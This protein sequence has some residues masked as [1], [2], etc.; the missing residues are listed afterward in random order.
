[1]DDLLSLSRVDIGERALEIERFHAEDLFDD[2]TRMMQPLVKAR[3]LMLRIDS[4]EAGIEIE[5]DMRTLRQALLNLVSNAIKFSKAG[6]MISIGCLCTEDKGLMIFVRDEGYGMAPEELPR[7]FEPFRTADPHV[8][9][10]TGATGLGLW[11]CKRIVEAHDGDI[12]IESTVGQ[13]TTVTVHLPA[14]T[15]VAGIEE[16]RQLAG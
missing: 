7:V 2:V 4:D 8:A 16:T 13:G 12:E 15:C 5:A 14:G 11:I 6:G 1:M 3:D 10:D 9:R